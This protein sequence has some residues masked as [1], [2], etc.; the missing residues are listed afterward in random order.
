MIAVTS[1]AEMLPILDFAAAQCCQ[2]AS[3]SEGELIF[4]CFPG[5]SPGQIC[6]SAMK[7]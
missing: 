6:G 5:C 4:A 2:N 3:S 7:R 1:S